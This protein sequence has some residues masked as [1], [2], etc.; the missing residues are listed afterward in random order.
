MGGD[1]KAKLVTRAELAVL[2]GPGH[3]TGVVR[4]GC[5]PE[6]WRV[7]IKHVEEQG[8][9]TQPNRAGRRATK[10]L[11]QKALTKKRIRSA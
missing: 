6:D 3:A 4:N 9:P 5:S 2:V 11:K 1:V 10:R 8:Q 7:W